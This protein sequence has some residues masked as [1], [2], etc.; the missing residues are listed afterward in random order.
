MSTGEAFDLSVKDGQ[1][2]TLTITAEVSADDFSATLETV[3][4]GTWST[5][6]DSISGG[7]ILSLLPTSEP[8]ILV[9]GLD[10]ETFVRKQFED[11]G[12]DV[13][14]DSVVVELAN[15]FIGEGPEF[16]PATFGYILEGDELS[17]STDTGEIVLTRSATTAVRTTTWGRV[18]QSTPFFPLGSRGL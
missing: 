6:E 18:K 4:E 8:E 5:G 12:L 9:D 7:N 3:V 11:A 10:V 14:S 16:G 13:P 1:A 2:F 15:E 17:L